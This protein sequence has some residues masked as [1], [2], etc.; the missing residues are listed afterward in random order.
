MAVL[1]GLDFKISR[2]SMPPRAPSSS[3]LPALG[4][5]FLN[6]LDPSLIWWVFPGGHLT[7][8]TNIPIP[9][10]ET[11]TK[12]WQRLKCGKAVSCKLYD[13]KFPIFREPWNGRFFLREAWSKPRPFYHPQQ[14]VRLG[15]ADRAASARSVQERS[16]ADILPIRPE[17]SVNK[18]FIT[19]LLVSEKTTTANAMSIQRA[20]IAAK[21]KLIV[22]V[23][24]L[25]QL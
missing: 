14:V 22:F 15:W 13:W 3:R 9:D 16:R 19:R 23:G 4:P 7:F 20:K 11:L 24:F 5:L 21:I 10:D 25:V 6:F 17:D 2:A 18:R 8:F 1:G 12:A